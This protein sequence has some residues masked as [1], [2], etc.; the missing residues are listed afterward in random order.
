MVMP[1]VSV[2][3]PVYNGVPWVAGAIQCVLD[4]SMTDF[5]LIVIDDGS[6]DD[7]WEIISKFRDPRIRAIQQ[8]NSGLAATLNIGI[9]LARA[10]YVARQDQD[11]WMHPDRL[12]HQ[13][14][15][16]KKNPECSAVGTW[17]EIRVDDKPSG[18]F[19]RHPTCNDALQL[20]LLFDNPFV[21]SSM[22]LRRDV[23]IDVGGYCE[24]RNRQPPEDYE[25]WSRL[26]RKFKVANIGE[27]LT[28]YREVAGS[29][30][31]VGVTPFQKNVL[32]ISAENIYYAL[33][34]HQRFEKCL[35]LS[36]LYHGVCIDESRSLSSWSAVAMLDS[37]V[38]ALVGK[39]AEMSDECR[40]IYKKMRSHVLARILRRYVP[41]RVIGLFKRIRNFIVRDA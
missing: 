35:A 1:A 16:M 18:R 15:Y 9:N 2:L 4:Q 36:A 39:K 19:H 32:R 3:L 6:K 20:F 11:D 14:E 40:D 31:R 28:A 38:Q 33:G 29:M 26:A 8:K 30:S 21:H 34:K 41:G 37:A 13:I 22:L 25:L 12:E 27:C 7:S 17:A 5:E 10:P 24:D 23:V